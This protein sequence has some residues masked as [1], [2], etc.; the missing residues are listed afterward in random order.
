VLEHGGRRDPGS[1]GNVAHTGPD[2]ALG[3]MERQ[4]S[5]N[6]LLSGARRRLG[7]LAQPIPSPNH[8]FTEHIVR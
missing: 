3:V 6:D 4:R 1:A 2:D 7:P 8:A 5:L